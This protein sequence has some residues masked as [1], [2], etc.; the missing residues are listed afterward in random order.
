[1]SVGQVRA[2]RRKNIA[3]YRGG[4]KRSVNEAVAA[5]RQRAARESFRKAI[6]PKKG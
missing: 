5:E 2:A 3:R 4:K 6:K 1:M